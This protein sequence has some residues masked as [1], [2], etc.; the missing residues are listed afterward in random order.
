MVRSR[1]QDFTYQENDQEVSTQ[2]AAGGGLY[3]NPIKADFKNFKPREGKNRI[4][5]LP[6]TWSDAEG[7]RHWAFPFWIHYQIGPDNAAYPCNQKMYGEDCPICEERARIS[8]S[9]DEE[10]ARQ[11]RPS[12]TQLAWV[13]DRNDE[14]SGPKVFRMP[15][16][17]LE[18]PIC[19][20]SRDE[21]TGAILKIDHPNEGFDVTFI[22]TG[23]QRNTDYTAPQVVRKPSYVSEEEEEQTGWL[24]FITENP[25][26]SVINKFSY[27]Y[28]SKV[29]SG[30][31]SSVKDVED[32]DGPVIPRSVRGS[33]GG[34]RKPPVNTT[35]DSEDSDDLDGADDAEEEI[36]PPVRSRTRG[37]ESP[38]KD[39][40]AS[41]R[42]GL[43]ARAQPPVTDP[44]EDS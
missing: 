43:R 14:V 12:L 22:R 44:D 29:F 24:T 38:K 31:V 30:V 20:L 19:E 41:I 37:S 33:G 13:I 17:K 21:E 26:P 1:S 2:H 28:V 6:R 5:I 32:D 40:R 18:G 39:L 23:S 8:N 11:L 35:T 25:L 9:G 3:D 16:K 27:E 4:R 10:T 36:R 34:G 42:G 15:A 7:P